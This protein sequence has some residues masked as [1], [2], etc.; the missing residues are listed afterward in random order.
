MATIK[1]RWREFIGHG[2]TIPCSREVKVDNAPS[3]RSEVSQMGYL[4]EQELGLPSE[5]TMIEV[6]EVTWEKTDSGWQ[7]REE[8][9]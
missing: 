9:V 4:L 8:E 7:Q 3:S 1:V 2:G 5:I 6:G